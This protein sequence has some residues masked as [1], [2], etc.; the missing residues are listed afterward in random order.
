MNRKSYFMYMTY[1]SQLRIVL[2][3]TV[4]IQNKLTMW[5]NDVITILTAAKWFKVLKVWL[6][7]NQ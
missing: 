2:F 4:S 1:L 3:Y 5:R 6:D 7:F